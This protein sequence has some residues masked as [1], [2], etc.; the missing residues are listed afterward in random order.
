MMTYM[1]GTELYSLVN[2]KLFEK[3]S[4]SVP[5]IIVSAF[6]NQSHFEKINSLGL[7]CYSKPINKGNVE[8]FYEKYLS[9]YENDQLI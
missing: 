9:K 4:K 2:T 1:N 8:Y 6:N 5:F 3:N 7:D